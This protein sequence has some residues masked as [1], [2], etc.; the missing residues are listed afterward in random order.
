MCGSELF[1]IFAG[2]FMYLPS[3]STHH[4]VG[5]GEVEVRVHPGSPAK[6]SDRSE[7]MRKN[8]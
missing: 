1:W 4:F 7:Q 5:L 3:I 2:G 6:P 8:M